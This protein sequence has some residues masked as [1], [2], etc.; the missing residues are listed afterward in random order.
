MAN[1][2]VER[3]I[4]DKEY[5]DHNDIMCL[6]QLPEHFGDVPAATLAE[7]VERAP[8]ICRFLTFE[9]MNLLR[10]YKLQHQIISFH[11]KLPPEGTQEHLVT[12]FQ[13]HLVTSVSTAPPRYP[14][15]RE[16]DESGMEQGELTA[17]LSNLLREYS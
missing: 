1:N 15:R 13:E 11:T 10:L 6:Q 17:T 3:E 16:M 5:L 14:R 9:K 7:R 8:Q 2:D 4:A 12:N